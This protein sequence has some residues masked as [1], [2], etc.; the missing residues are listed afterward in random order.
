MQYKHKGKLVISICA[1][2]VDG[3]S[4]RVL[5]LGL[6]AMGRRS[7]LNKLREMLLGCLQRQRDVAQYRTF[8]NSQ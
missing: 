3:I 6:E 1:R 8:C 2:G 4:E 7:F 5:A